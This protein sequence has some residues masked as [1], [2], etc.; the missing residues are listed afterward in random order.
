MKTLGNASQPLMAEKC[1]HVLCRSC[2]TKF[3]SPSKAK[4][5]TE[6]QACFVCD[7]ALTSKAKADRQIGAKREFTGLIQLRSDGTGF[8]ARGANTVQKQGIAFQC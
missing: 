4:T 7:Q 1:G 2:V 3:M 5:E 8:S 6:P